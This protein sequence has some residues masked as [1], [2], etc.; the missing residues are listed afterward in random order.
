MA[1]FIELIGASGATYRF[2]DW[3]DA[4]QT[5]MA[6]NF[7]VVEHRQGSVLIHMVGITD[8]LSKVPATVRAEGCATGEI[9]VR[10]NV[11]SQTR[12]SEHE[13]LVARHRPEKVYRPG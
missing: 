2:R 1:T 6:G 12:T 11:S 8:D 10:L 13:D 5:P 9:Y 7:V 4:G 3:S